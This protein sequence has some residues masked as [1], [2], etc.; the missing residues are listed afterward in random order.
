M[1]NNF[2]VYYY[3]DPRNDKI[4]YIGRGKNKRYRIHLNSSMLEK[5]SKKN[6]LIKEILSENLEPIIH[7]LI[8]NISFDES[9]RI[10]KEEI[11]RI[12]KQNLT[13][14][15]M[16]GQGVLGV[17]SFLGKKHSKET[18]LKMSLACQGDNNPMSGNKW[19]RSEDGKRTFREK[20][21]GEK[22]PMFGKHHSDKSKEKI[23]NAAKVQFSNILKCP[24]CN[25]EGKGPQMYQRHFK[26]CA[27][28]KGA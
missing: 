14:L 9:I 20:C 12:G 23:S 5:D 10:E 6:K 15:T 25:H 21:S 26:N 27:I 16:G 4:F 2:Y 8:E 19:F 18:K 1:E 11:S 13:N 28:L 7:F 24:N 17:K 3:I 22:H